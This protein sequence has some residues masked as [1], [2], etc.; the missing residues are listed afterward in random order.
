M[1]S[2]NPIDNN[3][4]PSK[5]PSTD[6]HP[7]TRSQGSPP[8]PVDLGAQDIT[9]PYTP[10]PPPAPNESADLLVDDSVDE[11]SPPLLSNPEDANF[12]C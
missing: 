10:L 2:K 12:M 11:G 6:K 7:R 4:N 8:N 9:R 5:V 1:P 3:D